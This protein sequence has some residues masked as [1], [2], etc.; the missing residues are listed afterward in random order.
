MYTFHISYHIISSHFVSYRIYVCIFSL[1]RQV[2]A[3]APAPEKDGPTMVMGAAAGGGD[4]PEQNPEQIAKML[5]EAAQKGPVDIADD[6][7]ADQIGTNAAPANAG[8]SGE[9]FPN[10]WNLLV[11]VPNGIRQAVGVVPAYKE[12]PP[13]LDKGGLTPQQ[14]RERNHA[15]YLAEKEKQETQKRRWTSQ[16]AQEP[17][18]LPPTAEPAE[19]PPAEPADLPPMPN[20]APATIEE[21]AQEPATCS[22][23]LEA[24]PPFPSV[25]PVE[26]HPPHDAPPGHMLGSTGSADTPQSA[27]RTRWRYFLTA[28]HASDMVNFID[29]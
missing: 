20:Q 24:P 7:W 18:N 10:V 8:R 21:A 26:P 4:P 28:S 1:V 3:A 23:D 14:K 17:Q 16:P 12:D 13:G 6:S 27:G 19:E 2:A 5:R 11:G 15:E 29:V 25:P 22:A 9:P